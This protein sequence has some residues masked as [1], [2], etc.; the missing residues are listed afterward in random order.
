MPSSDPGATSSPELRLSGLMS[1]QSLIRQNLHLSCCCNAPSGPAGFALK[2][3]AG[4]RAGTGSRPAFQASSSGPRAQPAKSGGC[5]LLSGAAAIGAAGQQL[6]WV[7]QHL[8]SAELCAT[9]ASRIRQQFPATAAPFSQQQL[10]SFFP[11]SQAKTQ[12][13]CPLFFPRCPS[14]Q[15]FGWLCRGKEMAALRSSAHPAL[16]GQ[17]LCC[18]E[19]HFQAS[20]QHGY[21]HIG[22]CLLAL[23]Y[24]CF[25]RVPQGSVLAP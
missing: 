25:G 19:D 15:H 3:V 12:R 5:R 9:N 14:L 21:L 1:L 16:K 10:L 20:P 8:D 17:F 13:P 23:H 22:L 7:S 6:G 2:Q 11:L 18:T 24:F 4:V